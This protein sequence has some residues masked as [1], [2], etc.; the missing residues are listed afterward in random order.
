M[1]CVSKGRMMATAA[2]LLYLVFAALGFGWR[3]WVH[4]RRTGSTGFRGISGTPA[5]VEWWAGAGFVAAVALGFAAPALQALGVVAPVEI[6]RRTPIQVLGVAL[7]VTGIAATVWAQR[8]MGE[9]WRIGV[10][11]TEKTTLVRR[12][13]F[14]VARN[15]IFTAMLIFGAGIALMA[16]NVLALIGF[17]VLFASIEAQVR[18]VEEPY[19]TAAHGEAYRDYTR[20]VGRFVPRIGRIR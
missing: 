13:V 12:G 19:L 10:D 8:E 2:L 20:S 9:S 15:P 7:A 6:L 3:T 16:P 17:V 11:A 14:G 18:A 5:S 4:H 1:S